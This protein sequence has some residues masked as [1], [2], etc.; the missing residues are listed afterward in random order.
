MDVADKGFKAANENKYS[1]L[2]GKIVIIIKQMEIF[3]KREE[4]IKEN[5]NKTLE[6]KRN[7]IHCMSLTAIADGDGRVS[8]TKNWC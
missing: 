2:V 7:K 4:N 3:S 5:Q 1:D 8:E 6:L